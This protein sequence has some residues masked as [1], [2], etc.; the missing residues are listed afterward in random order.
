MQLQFE[1]DVVGASAGAGLGAGPATGPGAGQPEAGGGRGSGAK[2]R[3]RGGRGSGK[4]PKQQKQAQKPCIVCR[5]PDKERCGKNAFCHECKSEYDAM[6]KDS[7]ENGWHARFEEGKENPV[8]FR[9]MLNDYRW[10]CASRGRG[11]LRPVYD[12]ARLETI[13]EMAHV[14]QRGEEAVMM[15]WFDFES[16]YSAK[17][18]NDKAIED[19]WREKLSEAENHPE[20]RDELGENPDYPTRI[21]VVTKTFR[22]DMQQ[23]AERSQLAQTHNFKKGVTDED[24]AAIRKQSREWGADGEPPQGSAKKARWSRAEAADAPQSSPS[25]LGSAAAMEDVGI[26]RLRAFE[27]QDEELCLRLQPALVG[28][29]KALRTAMSTEECSGPGIDE[30]LTVAKNRM[31]LAEVVLTDHDKNVP[32]RLL[33]GGDGERPENCQRWMRKLPRR[34]PRVRSRLAVPQKSSHLCIPTV[35][36]LEN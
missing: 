18:V 33:A 30:Y 10:Q 5:S 9:K 1:E 36:S 35:S 8:T 23:E 21:A 27:E 2:G 11:R 4:T 13:F 28:A 31:A 7:V 12:V 34:W 32:D 29:L 24:A 19:R 26:S 17:K 25:K 15:D 14:K 6:R 20:D 3:G 16:F 22:V